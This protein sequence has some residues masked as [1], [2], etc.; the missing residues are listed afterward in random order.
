MNPH[1][2]FVDDDA[3]FLD[4]L[5]RIGHAQRSQWGMTVEAFPMPCVTEILQP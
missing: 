5:R 4:G 2:L 3:T 1:V